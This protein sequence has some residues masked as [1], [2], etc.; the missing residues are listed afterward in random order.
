[1]KKAMFLIFYWALFILDTYGQDSNYVRLNA[2]KIE[3]QDSLEDNIYEAISPYQLLMVGEMHGSNEPARFIISLT[4]LLIKKGWNVQI[5]LEIPSEQ[6]EKFLFFP[7]DSNIYSSSFFTFKRPDSRASF[8]WAHIIEKYIGN[9]NVNIFYFDINTVNI[10]NVKDRDSLMYLNIKKRIL[11]HPSWKTLTLSGNVHN[12]LLPYD[13]E[14]KMGLYLFRDKELGIANKILSLNHTYS[15]GQIWD[16][17][18]GNLQLKPVD[19]SNSFFAKTVNYENCLLIYPPNPKMNYS[20]VYFTRKIT[21][22]N[23]VN[24]N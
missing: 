12:M 9:A 14:I 8:A 6:M 21:T 23:L 19:H 24:N 3:K 11:L 1:M 2:I 16:Y 4:D 5:G 10:Q 13:G 17:Y 18:G 22:S 20:G 7:N 15:T